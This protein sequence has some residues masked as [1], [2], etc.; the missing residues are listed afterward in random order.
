[1]RGMVVQ[2]TPTPKPGSHPARTFLFYLVRPERLHLVLPSL[3]LLMV[4]QGVP[5]GAVH[6]GGLSDTEVAGRE[7]ADRRSCKRT[8]TL[9]Q[10]GL[11]Q[12][13]RNHTRAFWARGHPYDLVTVCDWQA[14]S[15]LLVSAFWAL[16]CCVM[17]EWP[18]HFGPCY[19]CTDFLF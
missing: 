10:P 1:M 2:S 6:I 3:V 11:Q 17:M 4:S 12:R 18:T 9:R 5:A 13:D 19:R 15:S 16:H 7:A 14:L 8:M